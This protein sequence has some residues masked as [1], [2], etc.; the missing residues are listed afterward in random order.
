MCLYTT[1]FKDP[2]HVADSL[3]ARTL[4]F[5]QLLVIRRF[6]LAMAEVLKGSC[7]CERCSF[8]VPAAS[9][10]FGFA[11]CHCSLCRRIHASPIVLWSG[12]NASESKDFVVTAP[13]GGIGAFRSSDSCTRYFCN[14][15]GS[16]VYIKYDDGGSHQFA[17]ELHFPTSI[18][19]SRSLSILEKVSVITFCVCVDY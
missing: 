18:L 14:N 5:L 7:C 12:M 8:A 17:G 6:N 15:C 3:N 1:N 10:S 16:H 11:S 19:D 13:E 9:I 4:L 2:Q